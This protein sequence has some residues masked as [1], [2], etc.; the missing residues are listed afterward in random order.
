M[1]RWFFPPLFLL[2]LGGCGSGPGDDGLFS[3]LPV[4]RINDSGVLAMGERLYRQ[5]C[6]SCHGDTAEGDPHW[7]RVGEDGRFPPPPLDGSGHSWHHPSMV[8]KRVIHDGGPVGRSNMPPWGSKLSEQ[9]IEAVIAWFQSLWP[10]QAFEAWV[11]ME[12]EMRER[13]ASE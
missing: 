10:E 5:H 2:G 11:R 12:T 8:L 13:D 3:G 1:R 7:R 6:A 4:E 9:E